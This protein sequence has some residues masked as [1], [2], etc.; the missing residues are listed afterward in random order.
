MQQTKKFILI[1]DCDVHFEFWYVTFILNSDIL[2]P[3]LRLH[4]AMIYNLSKNHIHLWNRGLASL[5]MI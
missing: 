1:F 4:L 2:N 3:V 5:K